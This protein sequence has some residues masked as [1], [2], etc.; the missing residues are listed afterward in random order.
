MILLT[1]HV[2]VGFAA[3]GLLVVPGGML[4]AAARSR[5]VRFI[6]RVFAL[7]AFHGKV[8]GPLAILAGL[9]GFAVAGAVGVP[10]G[11]G[12]LIATYVAYVLMLVV[13]I[14]YHMRWEVRVLK[15]AQASPDGAPS[16]ELALAIDDPLGL[17]MLWVSAVLWIVIIVLMVAKPF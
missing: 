6:R 8:G 15:L 2:L 10:L 17:P 12:W 16:P 3:V 14:G 7:G 1:L 9:L 11:A 13:G 4:V 5:D